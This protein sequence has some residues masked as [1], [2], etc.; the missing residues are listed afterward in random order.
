MMGK[1]RLLKQTM[2]RMMAAV[3]VVLMLTQISI[4][5]TSLAATKT[6]TASTSKSTKKIPS[7]TKGTTKVTVKDGKASY[8][9]FKATRAGTYTFTISGLSGSSEKNDRINGCMAVGSSPASLF[10][11][12]YRT[13]GGK[14]T[15]YNL[16]SKAF[17]SS[18]YKYA[19]LGEKV[20][21]YLTSRTITIKMEKGQTLYFYNYFLAS[22]S[23]IRYTLK[24]KMK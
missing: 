10:E 6:V 14:T 11:K 18:Y 19:S 9:K 23:K 5:L 15:V 17:Y 8:F 13:E 1:G 12:E 16:C 21:R 22:S 4:P 2:R 7:V 24:I 3:L 20:N